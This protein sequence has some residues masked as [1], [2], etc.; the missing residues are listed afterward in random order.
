MKDATDGG[1]EIGE[2]CDHGIVFDEAEAK[3]L[4]EGWT[5]KTEAEFIV[6]NPASCEIRKRWPRLWGP[7]P[8]G[9]GFSGI[10]YA[11]YAHY[12]MGDW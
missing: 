10:G 4:L 9:C 1:V 8:K 11:S 3:K 5:P 2:P 7:C 12:I 6:G